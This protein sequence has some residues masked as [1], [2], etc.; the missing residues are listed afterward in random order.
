MK[1]PIQIIAAA[2]CVAGAAAFT[3]AR[4]AAIGR[5]L[6]SS[7]AASPSSATGAFSS[8]QRSAST[9][10]K[11]SAADFAKSAIDT[12]DVV[13]FSKSFC[14]FCKSTKELLAGMGIDAKVY[15]LN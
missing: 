13:V 15:E 11:M 5:V 3:I 1:L 2:S 9:S 10:L 14:P 12:N 6:G 8:Q 4:P 7:V